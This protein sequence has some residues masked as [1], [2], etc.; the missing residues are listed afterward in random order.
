MN[1]SKNETFTA[2]LAG[3]CML[4]FTLSSCTE[5]QSNISDAVS[6]QELA[7]ENSKMVV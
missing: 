3:I 7:P 5:S 4:A 2:L 6:D 1:H